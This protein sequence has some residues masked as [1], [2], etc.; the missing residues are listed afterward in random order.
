[1]SIEQFNKIFHM[2]GELQS[3]SRAMK[4][5]IAEIKE[6]VADYKKTKNRLIG[7]AAGISAVIGGGITTILNKIGI[8]I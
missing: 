3:D 1:M 7:V 6:G 5:D 4:E 2:L 8:G